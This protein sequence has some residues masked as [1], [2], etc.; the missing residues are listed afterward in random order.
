MSQ[1]PA[2][3]YPVQRQMIMNFTTSTATAVLPLGASN[4]IIEW[5]LRDPYCYDVDYGQIDEAI[6][7]IEAGVFQMVFP[8]VLN[9]VLS[10]VSKG[11]V[12]VFIVI[13]D[14]VAIEI[15]RSAGVLSLVMPYSNLGTHGLLVCSI[16]GFVSAVIL[17]AVVICDIIELRVHKKQEAEFF[18]SPRKHKMTI[19]ALRSNPF[20]PHSIVTCLED[21]AASIKSAA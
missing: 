2:G 16:F 17:L 9:I 4:L 5:C 10:F 3:D 12:L 13:I 15:A 21:P 11:L 14:V 19:A 18:T 1:L 7:L 8:G 20:R 6:Y